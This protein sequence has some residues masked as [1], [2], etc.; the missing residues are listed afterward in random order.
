MKYIQIGR[1]EIYLNKSWCF[2]KANAFCGCFIFDVGI[3]G[4]SW[5]SKE[6]NRPL[7]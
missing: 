2:G 4:F 3:I 7:E 5:L 6:C 1:L